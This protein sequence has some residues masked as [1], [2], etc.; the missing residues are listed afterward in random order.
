MGAVGLA[1][2]TAKS[3]KAR[4]FVKG[5]GPSELIGGEV[6]GSSRR[7]TFARRLGSLNARHVPFDILQSI[8]RENTRWDHLRK[9][10]S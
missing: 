6:S 7:R 8:R 1:R 5:S 9:F 4:G 10:D 2:A 3:S